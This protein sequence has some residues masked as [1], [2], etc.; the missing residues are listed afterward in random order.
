MNVE[1]PEGASCRACVSSTLRF[2]Q[3]LLIWGPK[4]IPDLARAIG[5]ARGEF[6]RASR[7]YVNP[8]ATVSAPTSDDILIETAKKLGINTE[9]KTKEQISQEIINASKPKTP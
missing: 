3:A 9:G 6:E 8:A 2:K 7:E 4:R 1:Q 5:Q